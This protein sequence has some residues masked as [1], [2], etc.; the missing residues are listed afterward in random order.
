MVYI[1]MI[2]L[3]YFQLDIEWS[4]VSTKNFTL[5][6]WLKYAKKKKSKFGQTNAV[7]G[8]F[9]RW[10]GDAKRIEEALL[11]CARLS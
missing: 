2:F 7:C 10:I 1:M 5:L 3:L 8:I 6:C 4:F 9:T 11:C